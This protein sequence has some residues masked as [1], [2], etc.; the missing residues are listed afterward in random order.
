VVITTLIIG[1]CALF[2]VQ[3][4]SLHAHVKGSLI[5]STAKLVLVIGLLLCSLVFASAA[6]IK[7]RALKKSNASIAGSYGYIALGKQSSLSPCL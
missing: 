7:A 2:T 6:I 1:I 4:N 5:S 3:R